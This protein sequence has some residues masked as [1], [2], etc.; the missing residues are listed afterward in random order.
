MLTA[1]EVFK[2]LRQQSGRGV[3]G[4]A[5]DADFL[6]GKGR[7]HNFG[8]ILNKTRKYTT[9]TDEELSPVQSLPSDI[10]HGNFPINYCCDYFEFLSILIVFSFN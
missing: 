8:Q 1:K 6:L 9:Y 3:H 2:A 5:L 4:V 7:S 10:S